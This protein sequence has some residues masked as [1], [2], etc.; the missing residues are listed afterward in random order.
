MKVGIDLGTTNSAVAFIDA[1]EAADADFPPIHVLPIEQQVDAH[2]IGTL[3]TL[4]SFL[5]LSDPP[6]V[7][8]YAREQGALV[9]TKTVHSAKSW[10]SNSEAD[11]TA[12]LLP[13]DAHEEGRV[14]SP[15]EA[16]AQY[17]SFLART[18]EQTRG[19]KLAQEGIVLTVPASF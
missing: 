19:S 18:W 8:A 11:R 4:P 10:L 2:R 15:V 3:R 17:L 6:V 13:W 7:G 1:A 14:L 12:K 16:S 9:P 5:F